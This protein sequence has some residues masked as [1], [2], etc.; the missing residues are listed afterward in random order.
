MTILIK[1]LPTE[2]HQTKTGENVVVFNS[3]DQ[4]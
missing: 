1:C 4:R 3:R 2:T